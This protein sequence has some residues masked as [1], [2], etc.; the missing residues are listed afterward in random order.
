MSE[1]YLFRGKVIYKAFLATELN[2]NNAIINKFVYG[3]LSVVND[4]EHGGLKA[5]IDINNPFTYDL[6][7]HCNVIEPAFSVYSIDPLTIRQ[8]T[9]LKDKNGKLIFEGDIVMLSYLEVDGTECFS[10]EYVAWRDGGWVT[11]DCYN[12]DR[13]YIVLGGSACADG[14]I[15]GNVH[16][17]PEFLEEA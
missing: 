2:N 9:G 4:A 17:N 10:N 3:S 7:E 14:E 1:R 15:I 6:N 11:F 5:R 13:E 12:D 8:C 16:D